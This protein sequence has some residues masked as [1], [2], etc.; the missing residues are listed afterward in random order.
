M[1]LGQT[2]GDDAGD[3]LLFHLLQPNPNPMVTEK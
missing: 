3:V 1:K 2:F